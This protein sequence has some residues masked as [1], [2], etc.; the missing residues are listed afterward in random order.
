[1]VRETL[2]SQ[3]LTF[4]T[5]KSSIHA[6]ISACDKEAISL[7]RFEFPGMNEALALERFG[8]RIY[9]R[10]S[11]ARVLA[12]LNDPEIRACVFDQQ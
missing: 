8:P 12:W 10:N 2:A 11:R 5:L 4:D 7:E 3:I 1:M 6:I 9:Y